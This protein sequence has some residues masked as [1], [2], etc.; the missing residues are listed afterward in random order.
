MVRFY[1]RTSFTVV[2]QKPG[3]NISGTVWKRKCTVAEPYL[4]TTL[5]F[6]SENGTETLLR[7]FF[8]SNIQYPAT[9]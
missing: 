2:A 9:L 4:D 3:K 6:K 5:C 7:P 1:Y 8:A